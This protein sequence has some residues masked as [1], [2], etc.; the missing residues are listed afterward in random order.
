MTITI[1]DYYAVRRGEMNIPYEEWIANLPSIY[2]LLVDRYERA[3]NDNL[4]DQPPIPGE[5]LGTGYWMTKEGIQIY[6]SYQTAISLG[7]K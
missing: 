2:S 5:N 4:P 1:E 7:Y 3:V 6:R